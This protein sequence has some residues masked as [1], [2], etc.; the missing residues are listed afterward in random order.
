[1]G[2]KCPFTIDD[3]K[4]NEWVLFTKPK[5]KECWIWNSQFLVGQVL[6][7]LGTHTQ[8]PVPKAFCLCTDSSVIGTAFYIMEYLDGRIFVDPTL[9]VWH[10]LDYIVYHD[11][12]ETISLNLLSFHLSNI[13]LRFLV[14][15]TISL[16][17][18]LVWLFLFHQGVSPDKRRAIYQATA[19][20]L[21]SLHSTNV[22][23]IG[24]T[25]YGRLDNY[26]KRQVMF[27]N[28]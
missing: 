23:A 12:F 28:F 2:G 1:M 18:C 5:G 21:A 14:Q 3:F 4:E 15:I 27:W 8:V 9:P 19:K 17:G 16:M 25:K 24:L 7:A 22:D 20:T 10:F 11:Q 26:C 6:R 13:V